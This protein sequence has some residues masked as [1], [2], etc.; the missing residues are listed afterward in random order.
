MYQQPCVADPNVYILERGDFHKAQKILDDLTP[1]RP[2]I[3]PHMCLNKEDSLPLCSVIM[4]S[5][6]KMKLW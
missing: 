2:N 1:L 6:R 4:G 3:C 5:E